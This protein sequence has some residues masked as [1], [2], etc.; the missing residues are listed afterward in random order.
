[1]QSRRNPIRWSVTVLVLAVLAGCGGGG[2]TAPRSIPGSGATASVL[3]SDSNVRAGGLQ[4]LRT[5][6]DDDVDP[7]GLIGV[8]V[9]IGNGG[10]PEKG[11]G[12][13]NGSNGGTVQVGHFRLTVPPG[14]FRG[15]ATVT[16]T[17]PEPS[18]LVCQLEISPASLNGFSAPVTLQGRFD[19]AKVQDPNNVAVMW[20]DPSARTW[21][22]VSAPGS[23]NGSSKT[24]VARLWHF[25]KYG[26]VQGRAG[27]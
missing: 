20:F 22:V 15:T 4:V 10:K 2:P 14:A 11:S 3:A 23:S 18:E 21:T 6:A 9:P 17:V 25:S 24:V 7:P 1:M 16:L 13:I 5:V 27:W 26:I 19:D 12:N 8:P